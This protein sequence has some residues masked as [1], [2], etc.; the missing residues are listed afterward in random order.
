M[1][2]LE[3]GACRLQLQG[4]SE[5]VRGVCATPDGC[6]AISCSED[7]AIRVFS[8]DSG[9]S[10][11]VLE[12]KVEERR[13]QWLELVVEAIIDRFER[14]LACEEIVCEAASAAPVEVARKLVEGQHQGQVG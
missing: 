6:R 14:D 2:D 7:G 9:A 11:S 4:H 5:V 13:F 10:I 8:L 1:W 12:G 3:S